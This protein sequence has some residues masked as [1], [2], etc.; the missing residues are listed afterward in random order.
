MP[1]AYIIVTVFKFNY[2]VI[3][4]IDLTRNKK[5]MVMYSIQKCDIVWLCEIR[6]RPCSEIEPSKHETL[7]QR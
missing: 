3:Y 2:L 6:K 5:L 1:C 7:A 4:F